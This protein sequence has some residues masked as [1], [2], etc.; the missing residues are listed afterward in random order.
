M[1]KFNTGF[2]VVAAK[3]TP[4]FF[5]VMTS[6]TLPLS[7]GIALETPIPHQ[8]NQVNAGLEI[9]KLVDLLAQSLPTANVNPPTVE[10]IKQV[11]KKQNATLVQYSIISEEVKIEGKQQSQESEIYIW[12]IPPNGEISLRRVD[13]KTWRE[14]EKTTL[15][16]LIKQIQQINGSGIERNKGIVVQ[17][18]VKENSAKLL[19]KQLHQLL[20]QPIAELLPNKPESRVIFIPQDKLFLVPFAALQDANNKYLI[21]KHT[22]S[23][24][25][26]IQLLDLLAQRR[27]ANTTS[28]QDVLIVGNPTMPTKPLNPGEEFRKFSPLP[29]A[30]QEAKNIASIYHTQALTGDA[31]TETTVVERMSKARI[32]HL[33]TSGLLGEYLEIPGLLAFAPSSQDDGWLTGSEVSKLKLNADLVVLSSCDSALGKITGD[34][35]IG[36]SRAFIAAGANS[37]ISAFGDI[38]D[39]QT[40]TLMTEF[41]NNLSKNPDKAAALRQ[42]MLATMKQH[43]NPQDWAMFTL[44]GLP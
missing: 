35:V 40:A 30:E 1:Q 2:S 4:V 11:A 19:W 26:S 8:Q 38:P 12:V 14:K 16:D 13:L 23:T 18:G 27:T 3:L 15:A 17:P 32:I 37:V 7:S 22:I 41:H 33:A 20:I 43:P 10:E 6:L 28:T 44:V 24:A 5:G 42:A 29:G 25:P 39:A 9:S 34:G 31:A 21:E 36:L